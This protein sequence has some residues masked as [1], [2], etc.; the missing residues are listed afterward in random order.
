MSKKSA[1]TTGFPFTNYVKNPVGPS[2]Q[3]GGG[4]FLRFYP[5][6]F[7]QQRCPTMSPPRQRK[8]YLLVPESLTLSEY[9]NS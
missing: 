8:N 1:D 4:Y 5:Y 3:T 2:L 6:L 9:L 7:L